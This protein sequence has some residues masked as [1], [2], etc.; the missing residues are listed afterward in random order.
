MSPEVQLPQLTKEVNIIL[1]KRKKKSH[2]GLRC[3]GQEREGADKPRS[4][5]TGTMLP[6]A[7][8]KKETCCPRK[9]NLCFIK[10]VGKKSHEHTHIIS[11]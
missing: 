3:L 4:V 11:T 6:F 1:L 10:G 7:G 5:A 2:V 9:N 8:N